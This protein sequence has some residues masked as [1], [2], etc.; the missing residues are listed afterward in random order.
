MF[1][2]CLMKAVCQATQSVPHFVVT[3]GEGHNRAE[4]DECA[5]GLQ[6][7]GYRGIG[8]FFLFKNSAFWSLD[9]SLLG[10]GQNLCLT[11]GK[12]TNKTQTTKATLFSLENWSLSFADKSAAAWGPNNEFRPGKNGEQESWAGLL[13]V[14]H[15]L[16]WAVQP[17]M[18]VLIT[19]LIN[20]LKHLYFYFFFFFLFFTSS[21]E[22][23]CC[24][25]PVSSQ[26]SLFHGILHTGGIQRRHKS[27]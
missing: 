8:F 12:A 3:G 18:H 24:H 21:L 2:G 14:L 25:G 7:W 1:S 22:A 11:R 16:W 15:H 27:S 17:A 4:E 10:L 26:K 6:Q 23:G 19:H 5:S 13:W 9:A 20:L